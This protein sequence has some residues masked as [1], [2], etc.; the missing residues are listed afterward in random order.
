MTYDPNQHVIYPGALDP[1]DFGEQELT[2]ET[3]PANPWKPTTAL[4]W[5]LVITAWCCT[6]AVVVAAWKW[7]F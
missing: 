5:W 3:D 1:V 6:P 7:G 4:L 2:V